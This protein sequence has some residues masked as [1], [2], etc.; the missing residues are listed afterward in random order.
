MKALPQKTVIA[1]IALLTPDFLLLTTGA[2]LFQTSLHFFVPVLPLFLASMGS[3]ERMIGLVMGL[4]S[5]SALVHRLISGRLV[6]RWGRVRCL[7]LGC[8]VVA[9]GAAVLPAVGRDVLVIP[10][11]VVLAGAMAIYMTAATTFAA[12]LAPT[13]HR[14]EAMAWFGLAAPL[15]MAIGPGVG[16][17]L[18]SRYGFTGAFA[19]SV[20]FALLAGAVSLPLLRRGDTPAGPEPRRRAGLIARPA[21][22]PSAVMLGLIASNG[23]VFAFIPGRAHALGLDNI[24]TFFVV[25]SLAMIAVRTQSGRLAD[26]LGRAVAILPGMVLAVASLV[27]IAMVGSPGLL[28][29]GGT[30]YGAALG[31]A[32]PAITAWVVDRVGAEE[33]ATGVAT[34]LMAMD[35]GIGV[36]SMSMGLLVASLGFGPAF[37]I[38][39]AVVAGA[40]ALFVAGWLR[41]HG[42]LV[43]RRSAVDRTVAVQ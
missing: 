2:L 18:L 33:R 20:T 34:L 41:E 22:L 23:A 13:S 37:L 40:G 35:V 32:T 21:L 3:T 5:F 26:R 36:G 19:G 31:A 14:G 25:Y 10:V 7:T 39:A 17:Y 27:L 6:D 28:L 15:A 9:A 42:R 38:V 11:R 24:G 43:V 12:D 16:G 4:G 30:L 29:L 1:P 8:L